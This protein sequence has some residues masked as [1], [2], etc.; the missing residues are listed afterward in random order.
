[1]I[2]EKDMADD[3]KESIDLVQDAL[4][5]IFYPF[6]KKAIDMLETDDGNIIDILNEA[7]GIMKSHRRKLLKK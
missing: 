1:M 6:N 5:G 4:D 7:I 3:L 2:T